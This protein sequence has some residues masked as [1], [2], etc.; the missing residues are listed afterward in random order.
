MR[1]LLFKLARYVTEEN[2]FG[3][4]DWYELPSHILST[5][6]Y[7]T[8]CGHEVTMQ[9]LF[10]GERLSFTGYD[11]V[12]EWVSLAEGLYE[13][14]YY[15]SLAKAQKCTTVLMLFD[16]WKGVQKEILRDYRHVDFAINGYDREI[17]LE[18]LIDS[19]K[20]KTTPNDYSGMVYRDDGN[21]IDGGLAEASSN[22]RHLTS[23]R[24]WIELL[25][26]KQYLHYFMRASF[27]CPFQCTFCHIGRRKNRFRPVQELIDELKAIPE[28]KAV[29]IGSADILQ[30][31]EWAYEFSE[32][33]LRENIKLHWE[34]DV[35]V[36]KITDPELLR[37]MQ[38]SGC[39][40]LALGIESLDQ[41]IL[42]ATKKNLNLDDVYNGID[43]AIAAGIR[44][45]LNMMLGHPLD[46]DETLQTTRARL[47]E[48]L[49]RGARLVGFQ[50]LRPLPGTEIERE[51]L[52]EGLL[53]KS[54]SYK[55]WFN[56]RNEPVVRTK[57]LSKEQLME[58]MGYMGSVI[59]EAQRER[60][61]VIAPIN[62]VKF[63]N[64]LAKRARGSLAV[65]RRQVGRLL[66]RAEKPLVQAEER[67]VEQPRSDSLR[68]VFS[69]SPHNLLIYRYVLEELKKTPNI[70]FITSKEF[71]AG[72]FDQKK[73]NV[74]LR[75]D[76]DFRPG[77]LH[78]LIDI[79]MDLALLSDVYVILDEGFYDLSPYTAY[80]RELHSQGFVVG[81]HTLA[82]G[83]DD[84]YSLFSRE[85]ER[86][87]AE[88]GFSPEYFTI[89]GKSP[90]P[91]NWAEKRQRFIE[92]IED[93]MSLFGL[94]GSHNLRSP[95]YWV[96]DSGTNKSGFSVLR[97]DFLRIPELLKSG[98]IGLLTHAIH[99]AEG[100][101]AWPSFE[102]ESKRHL[103]DIGS[104]RA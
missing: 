36:D 47:L 12:V 62:T 7:L 88:L 26:T 40:E 43:K 64:G 1:I 69:I 49:R 14:L 30:N 32:S 23:Y 73:I 75:H 66:K 8:G 2:R 103:F 46:S 29:K 15:L 37:I 5:A 68:E 79:E 19:L 44:P 59:T 90:H 97:R 89:H 78:T 96:E 83:N 72:R 80:V 51:C 34:T 18:R 39:T 84:F 101:V 71:F 10:P 57:Y 45:T 20:N 24:R 9:N 55:E 65:T 93:K 99:W 104:N 22:L 82:P 52:D 63:A 41:K 60:A 16:N 81:L 3:R 86:F 4:R 102:K 48:L 74:L 17:V 95:D 87:E 28:G 98:V 91:Q 85:L 21:V 94:K 70:A 11:V 67:A 25:G 92:D 76:V 53:E 27:G 13:G 35:R 42:K 54:L 56:S 50:F 61:T 38:R 100:D 31:P 58:W 6:E 33:L 77:K